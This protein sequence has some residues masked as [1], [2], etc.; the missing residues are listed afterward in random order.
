MGLLTRYRFPSYH[1]GEVPQ[2]YTTPIKLTYDSRM[3]VVHLYG[4]KG[5]GASAT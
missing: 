1:H 4:P 5:L 3:T 2:P